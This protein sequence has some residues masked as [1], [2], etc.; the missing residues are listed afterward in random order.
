MR[1][2]QTI[3]G[4]QFGQG[5]GSL[6]INTPEGVG[7]EII[8]RLNLWLGQWYLNLTDGTPWLTKVLGK[9]TGSTADATIQDRV[10]GSTGVLSIVSYSSSLNRTSRG[11]SVSMTVQTQFGQITITGFIPGI[12][13]PGDGAGYF[14]IG[15][16]A[17]GGSFAAPTAGLGSFTIGGSAA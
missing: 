4:R 13:R 11:F 12:P 16:S 1:V 3:N 10:L 15:D 5:Q 7:Q 14:A 2:R 17:I 6:F 8:T 9:F